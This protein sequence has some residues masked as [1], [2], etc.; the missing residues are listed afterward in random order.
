VVVGQ[1]HGRYRVE[2]PAQLRERR[3]KLLEIAGEAA[4]D[5]GERAV[6]VVEIPPD[7]PGAEPVDAVRDLLDRDAHDSS[8]RTS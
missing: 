2:R 1:D 4:I 7:P 6:D 3:G 5:N 8:R